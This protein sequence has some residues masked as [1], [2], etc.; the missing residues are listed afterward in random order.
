[1]HVAVDAPG[2]PAVLPADLPAGRTL[3]LT[4]AGPP[5]SVTVPVAATGVWAVRLGT[6]ATCALPDGDPTGVLG[7]AARL[8]RVLAALDDAG[9]VVVVAHAGA[10]H[11]ARERP[12]TSA[13]PARRWR[14]WSPSARRGRR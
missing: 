6:R 2:L 7:Q 14:P 9:D 5:E 4:A 3:D 11:A 10:G 1:V 12:P 8:R 13:P